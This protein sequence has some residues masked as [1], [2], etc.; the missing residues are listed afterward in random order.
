MV[1]FIIFLLGIG[2]LS[3]LLKLIK[4][5]GFAVLSIVSSLIGILVLF[6]LIY[7]WILVPGLQLFKRICIIIK[8][9]LILLGNAMEKHFSYRNDN[10]YWALVAT[11]MDRSNS[12]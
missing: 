4:D 2:I 10:K 7:K 6:R 9:G 5:I 12:I 11:S 8:S 3:K 1:T